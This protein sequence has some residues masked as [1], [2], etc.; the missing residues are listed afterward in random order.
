MYSYFGC[1]FTYRKKKSNSM[2]TIRYISFGLIWVDK[3]I[4]TVLTQNK[5]AFQKHNCS[6]IS[7]CFRLLRCR[8]TLSKWFKKDLIIHSTWSQ[9]DRTS[10]QLND[11]KHTFSFQMKL[12]KWWYQIHVHFII[13]PLVIKNVF[14]GFHRNKKL[15][16]NL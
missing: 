6:V 13:F 7:K 9:T 14:S 11:W 10:H 5:L 4:L 1:W 8:H 3:V 15:D 2:F 12:W 16:S